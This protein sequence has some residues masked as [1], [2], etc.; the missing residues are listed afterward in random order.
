MADDDA[1]GDAK[2]VFIT[3]NGETKKSSRGYTG[4]AIANYD[5]GDTYDGQF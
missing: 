2:Y 3:D 4:R 5:N 1:E